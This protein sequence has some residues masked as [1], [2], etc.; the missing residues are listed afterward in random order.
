MNYTIDHNQ[1]VAESFLATF[2]EKVQQHQTFFQRL[3]HRYRRP[4][5]HIRLFQSSETEQVDVAAC[6]KFSGGH[7]RV[8]EQG[9]DASELAD[10]V[11]IK[12]RIYFLQQS[13]TNRRTKRLKSVQSYLVGLSDLKQEANQPE[14]DQLLK[15]LMPTIRGVVVQYLSNSR[16]QVDPIFTIDDLIDEVYLA[17]YERFDQ[18]P[19]ADQ[20]FTA[21]VY[22]V[23]RETVDRI[24]GRYGLN[25]DS[26]DVSTIARLELKELEEPFT[27]DAEGDLIMYDELDD[28][29]YARKK[30]SHRLFT[31]DSLLELPVEPEAVDATVSKLLQQTDDKERTAFEL[32]WQHELTES[33]IAS[34][35]GMPEQKVEQLLHG[36]TDKLVDSIKTSKR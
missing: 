11:M 19:T 10:K 13:M 27:T 35:L 34:A 23:T 28:I 36:M 20:A 22:Q 33:E 26:I 8:D 6:L 7:I 12:L 24:I 4:Q 21:W 2:E 29:S 16:R 14:F 18:R 3:D 15:Q 30:W 1:T 5:L 32:F 9:S 17:I 31:Q 25:A